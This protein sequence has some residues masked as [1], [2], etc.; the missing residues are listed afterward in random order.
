MPPSA[1]AGL[2]G[3]SILC[4]SK[5]GPSCSPEWLYHFTFLPATQ[6][7]CSFFPDPCQLG[8]VTSFYFGHSTRYRVLVHCGFNLHFKKRLNALSCAHPLCSSVY[9]RLFL[10][11]NWT[12]FQMLDFLKSHFIKISFTHHTTHLVHTPPNSPI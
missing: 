9:S 6:Q 12:V 1:F 3:E 10:F 2:H 8:V 7:R 11:S 4:F 5:E